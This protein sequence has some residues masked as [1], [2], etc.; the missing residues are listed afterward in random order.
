MNTTLEKGLWPITTK[1]HILM[2]L[3]YKVVENIVRKRRAMSLDFTEER[4]THRHAIPHVDA[5][6]IYNCRKHCE[7]RRNCLLQAI[8]PFLT[9]F[10]TLC[11]LIFHF[12]C[13]LKCRLQFVSAWTS[14]KFCRLVMG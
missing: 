10:S 5:L 9:M 3:R 13:T 7:K 6:K 12:R 2:H 4:L 8:S 1:C 11:V 14:L